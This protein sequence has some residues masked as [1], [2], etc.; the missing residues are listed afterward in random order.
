[1]FR[2]R[3]YVSF[4]SSEIFSAH[5]MKILKG[6]SAEYLRRDFPELGKKYWGCIYGLGA[7]L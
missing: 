7:I 3:A 5:V 6:K 2:S 1:M 4:S